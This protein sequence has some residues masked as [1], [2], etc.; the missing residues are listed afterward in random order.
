[1]FASRDV[2]IWK[3]SGKH[4]CLMAMRKEAGQTRTSTSAHRKPWIS[5]LG[6]LRYRDYPW[7]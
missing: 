5:M 2:V 4:V 1:M 7:I 3:I 6:Y